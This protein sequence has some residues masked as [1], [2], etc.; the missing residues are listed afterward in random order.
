MGSQS[1]VENLHKQLTAFADANRLR[2]ENEALRL[3]LADALDRIAGFE[4]KLRDKS[5]DAVER[6]NLQCL[7]CDADMAPADELTSGKW[8]WE[9]GKQVECSNCG[10]VGRVETADGHHAELA[11]VDGPLDDDEEEEEER[12]MFGSDDGDF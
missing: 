8:S 2:E 7:C 12:D 3:Q 9:D 1:E 5:D 10:W 4:R 11:E 6:P